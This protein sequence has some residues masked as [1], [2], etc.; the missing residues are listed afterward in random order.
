MLLRI[1]SSVTSPFL[2]C[3]RRL[4]F[5]THSRFSRLRLRPSYIPQ[6]AERIRTD[7][8][9]LLLCASCW[10]PYVLGSYMSRWLQLTLTNVCLTMMAAIWNIDS[11][12][13]IC[14][15]HDS[16]LSVVNSVWVL[17][18]WRFSSLCILRLSSYLEG[19]LLSLLFLALIYS[20]AFYWRDMYCI[21]RVK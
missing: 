16:I 11:L 14:V 4:P 6:I 12:G 3:S 10:L 20:L 18:G 7:Y 21:G 17:K 9:R 15:S 1:V 5:L 19:V 13:C 2:P 8:E